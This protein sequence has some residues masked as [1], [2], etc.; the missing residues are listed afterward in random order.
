MKISIIVPVYNVEKYLSECI[1]SI[2]S[3]T[4][5]DWELILI[6]DGSPDNCD[7]ICLDYVKR[8]SRIKYVYQKNGGVSSARNKGLSLASGEFLFFMDSDDTISSKFLEHAYNKALTEKSDIVVLGNSFKNRMPLPTALPVMAFIVRNEFLKR[9]PEIIFPIG[10][11]PC[12]DGLFSHQL[13]ALTKK[14]SFEP[15]VKYNY[16][17]HD[18]Q[19]H[20]QIKKSCDKTL[21]QIPQW[22]NILV[23]FYNKHNLWKSHSLHLAKFLEHEPFELRY[24]DMPFNRKQHKQLFKMIRDFYKKNIRKNLKKQD[25]KKLT[26]RFRFFLFCPNYMIFNIYMYL[27]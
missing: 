26:K 3:Q 12:E 24:I 7:K 8:D 11:Q 22:F 1:D 25:R 27:F 9:F 19:N 4:L 16:R 14:I 2:I 17:K 6:N 13:L 23:S 10:L 5:T 15:N 20:L 21:S 18:S